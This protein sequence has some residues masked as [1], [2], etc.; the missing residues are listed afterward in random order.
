MEKKIIRRRFIWVTL[1]AVVMAGW[2]ASAQVRKASTETLTA[3]EPRVFVWREGTRG[4]RATL[5]T[6]T[7]AVVALR[8]VS[9]QSSAQHQ[10]HYERLGAA[11]SAAE[12]AGVP[13]FQQGGGNG[14]I[15]LPTG[16]VLVRLTKGT[17]PV[18][19]F[20]AQGVEYKDWYLDRLYLVETEPGWATLEAVSRLGE[21][22]GVESAQPN[23]WR[24]RGAQ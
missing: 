8:A 4:M 18:A 7:E 14:P 24:E 23:W 21:A 3:A 6:D 12:S 16:G 1:A 15:L 10:A 13:V 2:P 5:V 20:A 19:F 9:A 17:D 22:D 11:V